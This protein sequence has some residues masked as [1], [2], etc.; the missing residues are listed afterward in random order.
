[1]QKKYNQTAFIR[2]A[3]LTVGFLFSC[4]RVT[5]VEVIR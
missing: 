2:S 4:L 5:D 1:M 3:G